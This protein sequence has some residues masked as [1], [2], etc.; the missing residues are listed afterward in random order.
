MLSSLREVPR[1]LVSPLPELSRRAGAGQGSGQC[2][3]EAG[4]ERG[5]HAPALGMPTRAEFAKVHGG[6]P[7]CKKG[8]ETAA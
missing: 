2:L 3:R 1:T 4:R 5:R 7:E 6:A 8:K